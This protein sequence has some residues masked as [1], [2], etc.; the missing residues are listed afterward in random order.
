MAYLYRLV[1]FIDGQVLMALDPRYRVRSLLELLPQL[2]GGLGLK[3]THP[4]L[5]LE[6]L[7]G[8]GQHLLRMV[9][10]NELGLWQSMQGGLHHRS[11]PATCVQPRTGLPSQ[12]ED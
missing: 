12:G 2:L 5:F 1:P 6:L 9:G 10:Q 8:N 4:F 3:E 11:G 7:Y